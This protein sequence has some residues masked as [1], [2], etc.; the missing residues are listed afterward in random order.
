MFLSLHH[1]RQSAFAIQHAAAFEESCADLGSAK[2]RVAVI[3]AVACDLAVLDGNQCV[4]DAFTVSEIKGLHV[5]TGTVVEPKKLQ[6]D[7]DDHYL[8][9]HIRHSVRKSSEADLVS[10]DEDSDFD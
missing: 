6:E 10:E 3:A 4:R 1:A 8:P 9:E 5:F 7:D 2:V